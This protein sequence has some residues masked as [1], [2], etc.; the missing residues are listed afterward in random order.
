MKKT[1]IILLLLLVVLTSCN[2]ENIEEI[3][4]ELDNITSVHSFC[5]D[6]GVIYT[7]IEYYAFGELC[8]P[9]Y[10]EK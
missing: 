1:M 7:K 4:S 5:S 9:N 3:K 10:K 8:K 6:S 2:N